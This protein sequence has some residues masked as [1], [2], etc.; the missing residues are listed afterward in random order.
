VT[1]VPPNSNRGGY[2]LGLAGASASA[3]FV[4]ATAAGAPAS[5]TF[6]LGDLSVDQ[7]G[8]L[9]VCTVAGTPGTWLAVAGTSGARATIADAAGGAIVDTQARAALNALLAELRTRSLLTP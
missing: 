2:P 5:G 4:G 6:A 1:L 7:A 3:R 9:Y 8:A